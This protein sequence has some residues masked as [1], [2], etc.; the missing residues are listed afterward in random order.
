MKVVQTY[1]QTEQ[2]VFV[3]S[4]GNIY[5]TRMT[6]CMTLCSVQTTVDYSLLNI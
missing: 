2:G 4:E 6:L 5:Q 1:L 3:G